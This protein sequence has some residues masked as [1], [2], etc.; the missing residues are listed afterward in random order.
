MISAYQDMVPENVDEYFKEVYADLDNNFEM[1][2]IFWIQ[3][4]L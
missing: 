1:F 3:P 4:Y 2:P